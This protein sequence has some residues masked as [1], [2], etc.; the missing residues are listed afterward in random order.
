[1]RNSSRSVDN[2]AL[3]AT[4]DMLEDE[5]S[6]LDLSLQS[7]NFGSTFQIALEVLAINTDDLEEE[8]DEFLSSIAT[9]TWKL[10]ELDLKV[11][12]YM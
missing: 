1:M 2:M 5:R 4:I 11:A 10:E 9:E 8:E 6:G 3:E 7:F 12:H